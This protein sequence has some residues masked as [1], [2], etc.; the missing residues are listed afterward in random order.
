MATGFHGFHVLVGTIFLSVCLW[1]VYQMQFT[2]KSH[3]GFEAAAWYWHF[4]D[5]VWL[6][7]FVAIYFWGGM[8]H[9]TPISP[10][11]PAS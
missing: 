11:A 9:G 4:V 1:R 7:L 3:F 8:P 2:P 10:I 5:V 6:F